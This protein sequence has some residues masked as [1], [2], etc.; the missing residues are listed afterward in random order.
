[1]SE[2][3][4][5]TTPLHDR[6][7]AAGAKMAPFAGFEMPIQYSGILDEH[8]AV[9]EAAGLFDVSHMGE[10]RLRGPDALALAQRLVTNDVSTLDD[11]KAL[12]AVLCHDA[13]GAVDDL[14]VYR[15]A[16]DDV[17][18]VVNASNI[19]KDWAHV[20]AV[21]ERAGL[22]VEVEDESADTAL[23]AL[24]G[25]R[26]FEIF[27]AATGIDMSDVGSYRFVRP[28]PGAVFGAQRALVST[29]GYTGEPGLE[30]YLEN[31][32]A[33]RAWDALLEAGAERGLVPAGLGARDTLRLE[34]GFSLYGHELTDDT[35]PYEAN[36]GWVVKP[37]AGD[38]VGRDALVQ[39]K[40]DG[41]PRRIVGLVVEGRG[42]PRE[43][44]PIVDEG[45][46]EVGVV[47]SGSQSPAL[48]AGVALGFVP[49]EPAYTAPGTRL[50]VSVRGRVLPA[51]V[52]KPPFHRAS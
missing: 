49:N 48:G 37:D 44:Y 31:E 14:L 21:A 6:H 50:G 12:Y 47:T 23:L 20:T 52:T 8:R 51:T 35:T 10:F 41:V 39:Q 38:F 26:A 40:A 32:A 16:E 45:G 3:D 43:G 4:L 19:E 1:M 5:R 13:G 11:G 42:I 33:G 34:A 29:T 22:D 46:A 7:L 15:V 30:I 18:L 28:A 36:L 9:R 2:T 24:Q 27:E 17:M 25:P